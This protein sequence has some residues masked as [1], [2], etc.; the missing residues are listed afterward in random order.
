MDLS[1]KVLSRGWE[2]RMF[3]TTENTESAFAGTEGVL[4]M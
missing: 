1:R 2:L 4:G 3:K